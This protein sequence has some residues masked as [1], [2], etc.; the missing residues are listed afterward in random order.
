MGKLKNMDS[1]DIF[2][3]TLGKRIRPIIIEQ[4]KDNEKTPEEYS[5][6]ESKKSSA[7]TDKE[8]TAV[9]EPP[10]K[11]AIENTTETIPVLQTPVVKIH[12]ENFKT[13]P[14]IL[15]NLRLSP[16]YMDFETSYQEVSNRMLEQ[17]LDKPIG[18][19]LLS[20]DIEKLKDISQKRRRSLSAMINIILFAYKQS[21]ETNEEM[22]AMPISDLATYILKQKGYGKKSSEFISVR[23]LKENSAFLKKIVEKTGEKKSTLLCLIIHVYLELCM[24]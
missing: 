2:A 20:D 19:T 5:V 22:A 9:I 24:S 12:E 23:L 13:L 18:T 7:I 4:E 17:K 1:D 14:S 16:N 11:S 10:T 8:K 3:S 6:S 15:E 21:I